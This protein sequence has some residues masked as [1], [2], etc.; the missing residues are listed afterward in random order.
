VVAAITLHP[1]GGGVAA[2]SRLIWDTVRARCGSRSRL[3]T[4]VPND[5]PASVETS[6][7]DRLA[8]GARV[9]ALQTAGRCA[10]TFY[11]HLSLARVQRFVPA[12]PRPYM[13][14]LHGIEAWRP[15]TRSETRVLA[16]ASLRVANSTYTAHRVQ[17]Q[18]P[19]VGPIMICPLAMPPPWSPTATTATDS[20]GIGPHAVV[21]VARMAAGER[22]KG[23]DALLAAWPMVLARQP[24]AQLVIVGSGDDEARLRARAQ[25]GGVGARVLFTGFVDEASLAA[26]Y[27]RAAVFAMPSRGEGFGIAYLEAMAHGLPCIGSVHDAAG[28]VI[29]DG[30]TGYLIDQSDT[31]ALAD[32]VSCLLGNDARRREM[33]KAGR[34]RLSERFTADRFARRLGDLVDEALNAETPSGAWRTS[35]TH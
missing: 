9:A 26:I 32:R 13:V 6:T 34:R 23:H 15:L 24:D 21:I 28:E 16:G 1:A 29:D 30:V 14:F 10:W 4:L 2:V 20:H 18:H 19:N 22:Y 8:F 7:I 12:R 25:E 17:E 3:V 31:Q 5:R 27:A 35:R 33:G 11:S